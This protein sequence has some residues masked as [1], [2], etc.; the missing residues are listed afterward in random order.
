[1]KAEQERVEAE[2]RSAFTG[3]S[4]FHRVYDVDYHLRYPRPW[5]AGDVAL[6]FV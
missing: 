5:E 2:L 1:V 6:G 3:C 4:I